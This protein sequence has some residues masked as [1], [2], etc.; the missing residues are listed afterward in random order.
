VEGICEA[1]DYRVR[2][3]DG[4]ERHLRLALPKSEG[5]FNWP[6]ELIGWLTID[7]CTTYD[8]R[9]LGILEASGVKSNLSSQAVQHFVSRDKIEARVTLSLIRR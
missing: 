5:I 8:R 3:F 1:I 9:G 2:S 4:R 7:V 6:M